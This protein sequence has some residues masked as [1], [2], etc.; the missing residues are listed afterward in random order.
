VCDA[1]R[2][3]TTGWDPMVELDMLLYVADFA[4]PG[5]SA[6]GA[7]HVRDLAMSDLEAA[8]LTAMT[9][10]LR[11]LLDRGATIHARTVHARNALIARRE[12]GER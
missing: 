5:R 7:S 10:K 12:E 3:H 6:E 1:I 11:R 2:A 8:T 4:E 9:L